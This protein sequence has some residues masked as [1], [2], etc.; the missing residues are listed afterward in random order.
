MFLF[1]VS[2]LVVHA[3]ECRCVVDMECDKRLFHVGE[4]YI[5]VDAYVLTCL[6]EIIAASVVV[7]VAET[8]VT[9]AEEGHRGVMSD[10]VDPEKTYRLVVTNARHVIVFSYSINIAKRAVACI[11]TIFIAFPLGVVALL[12]TAF[13]CGESLVIVMMDGYLVAESHIIIYGVVYL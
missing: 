11:F 9:E 6:V 4:I 7:A 1:H 2:H 10:V 13:Q 8:H 3:V 12:R 5:A